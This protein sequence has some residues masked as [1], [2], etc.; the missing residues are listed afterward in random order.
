MRF[1]TRS[2]SCRSG[3]GLLAALLWSCASLAA[4]SESEV[5]LAL[6]Y[7][8][9]RL[10]EWP[11]EPDGDTVEF[12]VLGDDP[13]GS[14]L[15]QLSQRQLHSRPIVARSLS[16][17]SADLLTCRILFVADVPS[18]EEEA[19]IAAVREHPVLLISDQPGF[20]QRGGL[21]ELQTR[22]NRIS[23]AVNLDA[24]QLSGLSISSQLLELATLVD[25]KEP[26]DD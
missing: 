7:N 13:F 12:C 22:N 24:Q 16:D 9:A 21:I 2:A 5:K 8:L 1:L 25:D 18:A 11:D 6:S 15:A 14:D 10:V 20:A 19:L 4:I 17:T 26:D 3:I 23:F